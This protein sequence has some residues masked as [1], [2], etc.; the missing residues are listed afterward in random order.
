MRPG[1]IYLDSYGANGDN[2]FWNMLLC[3]AGLEAWLQLP[4]NDSTYG[5]DIVLKANEWHASLVPVCMGAGYQPGGVHLVARSIL[6]IHSLRHQ[7]FRSAGQL[8][9]VFG[10]LQGLMFAHTS[11]CHWCR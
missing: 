10:H 4:I 5:E 8:T 2:Q 1:G 9:D 11:P 7:G 3:L 6:A